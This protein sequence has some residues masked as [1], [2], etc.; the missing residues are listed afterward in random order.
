MNFGIFICIQKLYDVLYKLFSFS[1]KKRQPSDGV[2]HGHVLISFL[3]MRAAYDF[4]VIWFF[5]LIIKYTMKCDS[6]DVR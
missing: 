3:F 2:R 6:I 4:A 1:C 5:A